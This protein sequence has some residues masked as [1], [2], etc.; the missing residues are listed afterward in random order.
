MADHGNRARAPGLFQLI[1]IYQNVWWDVVMVCTSSNMKTPYTGEGHVG[2][3]ILAAFD[4]RLR[5]YIFDNA[6]VLRKVGVIHICA[7]QP[8]TSWIVPD[9]CARS[10]TA[11]DYE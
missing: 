5:T 1:T 8:T 3:N 6:S 9:L 4:K 7:H 10:P 2:L 11:L